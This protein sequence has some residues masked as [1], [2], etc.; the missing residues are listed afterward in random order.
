MTSAGAATARRRRTAREVREFLLAWDR[1]RPGQFIGKGHPVGDFLEAHAW[2]VLEEADGQL[3]VRAH[4]PRQVRN[5]RGQMFGGFTPTYADLVSV[6]TVHAG[7]LP[8]AP[9]LRCWLATAG[10][11]LDYFEPI[12][13]PAFVMDS[14]LMRTRGQTHFVE[15][16]F[17]D[18]DGVLLAF[19]VT[20]LRE[21]PLDWE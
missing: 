5:L 11:R 21:V 13:G 9:A 7:R 8:G 18:E 20:T 1:R 17:E 10:L 6:F 12:R 14:R 2:R 16:R 15:T 19:A 4:L 3:R